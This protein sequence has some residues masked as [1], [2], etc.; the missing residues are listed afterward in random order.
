MSTSPHRSGDLEGRRILVVD[1]D[2]TV[3]E[4]AGTYLS[5]AGFVVDRAADGGEALRR[6]AALAPDL[7]VLDVMLPDIDGIETCRR[8]R[9]AGDTAV[10]MLTARTSQDDRIIG[11]E[12]GADDYLT[13]PFSPR[14]LVLRVQSVLRRTTLAAPI[15]APIVCGGYRVD[16]AARIA[17]YEGS[18]LNLT[19]REFDLLEYLAR[20][21]GQA[22]DRAR[23]LQAVWGWSIGDLSTVTVHVRRL[24]EKIEPDP[25]EPRHLVT[26][27][28]VGYRFDPTGSPP[29]EVRPE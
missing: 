26:V 7:V 14:E 5:A 16:P 15:D 18:E 12:A 8:I 24:R 13:K 10:L 28:G 2:P 1:D 22:F 11:L 20:R 3:A 17:T 19:A 23:L 21:P 27:W 25:T 29:S 4:V 6:L 9:A